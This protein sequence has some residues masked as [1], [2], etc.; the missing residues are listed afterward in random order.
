MLNL[1]FGT[2][3]PSTGN[4]CS[5]SCSFVIKF[6]G[7][8]LDLCQR[9][10]QP[11]RR[12][13]QRH[14]FFRP[15]L[16]LDLSL[17]TATA[18]DTG[19]AH[20]DVA[21]VISAVNERRY[22]QE[23]FLVQQHGVDDIANGDTDRP[24]RAALAFDDFGAAAFGT[25][26]DGVL[27]ARRALGQPGQRQAVG[28]GAGPDGHH[29]V[30]VF[31]QDESLDLGRRQLEFVG[32]E[33]AEAGSVE[34]RAEAIDLLPWQT[35]PLHREMGKD[36]DRVRDHEDVGIL[37]RARGFDAVEDLHEQCDIAIDEV[38]PRLVGLAAQ[39]GG[40]EEEV[41]IGCARVV[42]R[43]DFLVAAEGAAVEQVERF[44]LGHV[45][46]GVEDLYLSDQ[47]GALQGER[48]AGTDAATAAND[49]DFHE[50]RVGCW[51]WVAGGLVRML[52]GWPGL[53]S[54]RMSVMSE[55]SS[56]P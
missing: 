13:L 14:G 36:I 26:E 17:N 19:H 51:L 23:R 32:D 27:E 7:S 24:T 39:S 48:R 6:I 41:A 54:M 46:V 3:H 21:D 33:R 50:K 53:R 34:H 44:A 40:D 47:S 16:D 29:R 38:E 52:R 8:N 5:H 11:L 22:R 10:L 43:I 49:C 15:Q 31:T 45:P 30:A 18:D 25:L 56:S 28:G 37:A 1:R 9:I 12:V 35:T 55:T 4:S 20:T 2:R 42:T